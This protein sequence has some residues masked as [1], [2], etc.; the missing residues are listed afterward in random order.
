MKPNENYQTWAGSAS[1][2]SFRTEWKF[3]NR[4]EFFGRGWKSENRVEISE[5]GWNHVIVTTL[6]CW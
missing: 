2:W 3:E 6:W 1:D 4:M 5:T